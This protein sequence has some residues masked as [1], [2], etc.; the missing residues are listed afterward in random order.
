MN[1]KNLIKK[2]ISV[3]VAATMCL[4]IAGCGNKEETSHFR[5]GEKFS[6]DSMQNQQQDKTESNKTAPSDNTEAKEY[7]K[8]EL[9]DA[10]YKSEYIGIS[11]TAPEGYIM[12]SAEE[13]QN[14]NYQSAQSQDEGEKYMKYEMIAINPDDILQVI[15]AVD[16]NKGDY[17]E[18]TYLAYVSKNYETN[19]DSTAE[20][21]ATYKRI[22]GKEFCV[23]KID[24]AM[25]TINY[26]VRKSGTDMINIII[27]TPKDADDKT[28]EIMSAFKAY[29]G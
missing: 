11:F 19:T 16:Q 15:V 29:N 10:D 21:K 17:D 25:G 1:K 13:I 22:G 12:N 4:T 7:E 8:G 28:E 18:A 9:T 5:E 2:Y 27:L 6:L 3:F 24:A 20:N 23:M 26:C 14:I